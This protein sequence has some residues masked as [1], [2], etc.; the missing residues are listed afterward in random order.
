MTLGEDLP[1]CKIEPA[2]PT[3]STQSVAP[4]PWIER[5]AVRNVDRSFQTRHGSFMAIE[6]M[7]WVEAQLE[8][9]KAFSIPLEF[10]HFVAR[11]QNIKGQLEFFIDREDSLSQVTVEVSAAGRPVTTLSFYGPFDQKKEVSFP[12]S[13]LK[14]GRTTMTLRLLADRATSATASQEGGLWFDQA[15][16]SYAALPRLIAG[17]LTLSRDKPTTQTEW[18]HLPD[19]D[20]NSTMPLLAL[21]VTPAGEAGG[22]WPVTVDKA[23]QRGIIWKPQGG[24]RIEFFDMRSIPNA[25]LMEPVDADNLTA[26]DQG[27]DLIVI[28]HREFMDAAKALAEFHRKEGWTVRLVDVQSIYDAFSDG[29]LSP[30]GIKAF[31]GYALRRWK[32]GTPGFVL[33]VGDCSSDYLNLTRNEN[34]RNWVPTYTYSNGS[35]KWASDY[36][37][38]TVAGN[39][40]LGDL[41]LGRISVTNRKDA[42]SIVDKILDYAANTRPGPWHA[43]LAY[44]ADDGEFPEVIEQIRK[45]DTPPAYGAERVFLSEM[46]LE[47]NWY[48][49]KN[50]VERKRMKVSR[51]TT[52]AI[53][54]TFQKGVAYLTYYG[55]GSPNI[56]A[57]E[58]IWFGGDSAN[59]DNNHLA[60]TGLCPF[61]ANMT[62]NSG[63]IDYPLVPWNIC[64]TEDMMRVPGGGAIAC[65][66]PSGP[67]V[68]TVHREMS[69]ALRR[70][71]FQDGLRRMGEFTTLAKAEYSVAHEPKELLYMYQLLGD[72]LL[73]LNLTVKR[74]Q[75]TPTPRVL[76]P[77]GSLNLT[78]TGI[79]PAEGQW[80][81]EWADEGGKILWSAEATSYQGGQ[82][83]LKAQLPA[84]AKA[85][86]TFLRLYCWDPNGKDD[87]ALSGQV[88]IER[89]SLVLDSLEME[90]A[91]PKA[92]ANNTSKNS[93]TKLPASGARTIKIGLKNPGQLEAQGEL[94]VRLLDN[95]TSQTLNTQPIRLA[96]RQQQTVT[97]SLPET[98]RTQP[99]V[100]EAVLRLPATPDD[101][102][103]PQVMTKRVL[104]EIPTGW[105]GWIEPLCTLESPRWNDLVTLHAVGAMPSTPG[106][107]QAALQA[108]QGQYLAVQKLVH[109]P[110]TP[111][112]DGRRDIQPG[113]LYA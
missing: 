97:V 100:A 42:Q 52:E 20:G 3:T 13:C 71:L 89:P 59:S 21:R 62:C 64:I 104:A 32:G 98:P 16:F 9:G 78:L 88:S 39:D 73:D 93:A 61:I 37:Y 80:V 108:P 28:T 58:R 34:V 36:W 60:G 81:G 27:A 113:P 79:E 110:D 10:P 53:L 2:A 96:P 102:A 86:S 72:P 85:G 103:Q 65:F 38:T 23:G 41:M 75:F 15:H 69:R 33:L 44:I 107:W 24:E 90:R 63:A 48:L 12:E 4:I 7:Q 77:G 101:P 22:L 29:E 43:R 31:L 68:T 111:A 5:P 76:A 70:A 66:V 55:H 1:V 50:Y 57:D 19:L 74:A 54:K 51:A 87:L 84:D 26:E 8:E 35:D 40:D 109:E 14:D 105:A 45:Q 17:R 99:A 56:W 83:T 92:A 46:P 67:G 18:I 11:G 6:G 91:F 112:G 25:P 106:D 94:E 82:I 47:D 49:P 95:K 30:E